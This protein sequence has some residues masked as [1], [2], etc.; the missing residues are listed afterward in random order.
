MPGTS[1][2][3]PKGSLGIMQNLSTLHP[4]LRCIRK[5]L[6]QACP[7]ASV[8]VPGSCW[9]PAK[10]RTSVAACSVTMSL[11][12]TVRLLPL[13]VSWTATSSSHS[14]TLSLHRFYCWPCQF[15]CW[16]SPTM[17]KRLP[18]YSLIWIR[19]RPAWMQPGRSPRKAANRRRS[20]LRAAAS[21]CRTTH[22]FHLVYNGGPHGPASAST[23]WAKITH[24]SWHVVGMDGRRLERAASAQPVM[25]VQKDQQTECV[26]NGYDPAEGSKGERPVGNSRWLGQGHGLGARHR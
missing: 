5:R 16:H 13:M 2:P 1:S 11:S 25:A 24:A 3:R 26:G 6:A 21:C 15:M 18:W 22:T 20:A 12:V 7:G 19:S 9:T 8:S 10:G 17:I 4:K 23:V 14:P